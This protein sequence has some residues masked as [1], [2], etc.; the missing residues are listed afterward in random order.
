MVKQDANSKESILE[1]DP[2][3]QS[4]DLR[5]SDKAKPLGFSQRTPYIETHYLE[6]G[7]ESGQ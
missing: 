5:D 1:S 6:N 3:F 2:Q 4:I 7:L